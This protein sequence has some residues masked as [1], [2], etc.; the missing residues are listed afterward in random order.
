MPLLHMIKI[1]K[2][3][4]C[5]DRTFDWLSKGDIPSDP[6]Y[7][8]G[9]NGN[10]MSVWY[11]ENQEIT[12]RIVA[13]LASNKQDIQE[14]NFLIIEENELKEHEFKIVHANGSTPDNELNLN[15]HHN[16]TDISAHK[17]LNYVKHLWNMDQQKFIDKIIRFQPKDVMNHI[18]QGITNGWIKERILSEKI[19]RKLYPNHE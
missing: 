18:K 10:S 11:Y 8:F 3:Y 1:N 17:I 16:I 14:I 19:K 15:F 4:L 9:I 13:A 12:H 7:S 2:W 6:L 5:S